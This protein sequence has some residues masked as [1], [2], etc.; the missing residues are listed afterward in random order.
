[1]L[2]ERDRVGGRRRSA[3]KNRGNRGGD[4]FPG[5]KPAAFE[6]LHG[7]FRGSNQTGAM[8]NTRFDHSL[9]QNHE[10]SWE[11]STASIDPL[12]QVTVIKIQGNS[13]AVQHKDAD[14]TCCVPSRA[15]LSVSIL[16]GNDKGDPHWI[17]FIRISRIIGT[18]NTCQPAHTAAKPRTRPLTAGQVTAG[19]APVVPPWQ[20][21]VFSPRRPD[22]S[23]R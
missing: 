23:S 16:P 19:Q 2:V 20:Q 21:T 1:M 14:H 4:V 5:K 12:E 10:N 13:T 22:K 8:T 6:R 17:A 9:A 15:G 18:P 7:H 3:R 11:T